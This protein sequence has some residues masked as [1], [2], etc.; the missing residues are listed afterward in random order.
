MRRNFLTVMLTVAIVTFFLSSC[1]DAPADESS[2]STQTEVATDVA[3]EEPVV[4]SHE[5]HNHETMG[6]VTYQC[7]MK[8][9]GNKTYTEKG[10][11]PKCKMDLEEV[12]TENMQKIIIRFFHK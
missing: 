6:D 12:K 9:E 3:T 2:N 1:C 8:C 4:D 11:C 7:P 10:T 5:G